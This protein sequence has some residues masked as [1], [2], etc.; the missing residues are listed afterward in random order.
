MTQKKISTPVLELKRVSK[1][2]HLGDQTLYALNHISTVI[3][4]GEFVAVVGPSGSG[5]STFL[6]IAS[7]LDTPS[8]G[9][10]YINQKETVAYTEEERARLRN[11]EIGFIF[12]QFNLLAKTSAMENVSLP[13]VYAN[14][15]KKERDG[16]AKAMLTK[17][18]LGER[19]QN[20][21]AQLSGGQQQRVAIAR[22][23]INEP[24]IIFADE[25]TGN[26][27][28][29]SGKEIR[30]YLVQLHREGRTLVMVTHDLNLAKIASR[31]IHMKDGDI[32]KDTKVWN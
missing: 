19:L 5:K 26:L 14:V 3:Y 32:V 22:A 13:L 8:E 11:R 29:N 27:D 31:I 23:L 17:V 28:S 2:Y 4:E 15:P 21:P 16:R 9:Q 24:S 10:V 12:Q 7:L 30:E 25:P 18:G 20:T 6:H 1:V